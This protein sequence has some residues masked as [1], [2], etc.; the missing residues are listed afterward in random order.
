MLLCF[1]YFLSF[2]SC[3]KE[4]LEFDS[5]NISNVIVPRSNDTESPFPCEC[6]FE[7][8]EITLNNGNPIPDDWT[9]SFSDGTKNLY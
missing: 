7:I 6:T 1:Y 4:E 3:E 2:Q 9:Y 5:E 8:L